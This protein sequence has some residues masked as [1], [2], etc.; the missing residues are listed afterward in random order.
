MKVVVTSGKGGTGKTILAA[1]LAY[2]AEKEKFD[3]QYLD[4]D[5]DE[6]NGHIF[7]KPI[8]Q[9]KE[10]VDLLIPEVDANKCTLCG[11]CS[12]IC[13]FKA[14]IKIADKII[15]FP[16]L[17]HGCGACS[18][19]CEPK[20]IKEI[21]FNVGEI[22]TAQINNLEFVQGKMGIGKSSTSTIIKELKRKI[23]LNSLSFLDSPPGTACPVV[24]SLRNMDYVV[25]V[26][27]PTPFG[28]NDMLLSIDLI[29]E[30]KIPFG[31][32]INRS[33]IGDDEVKKYCFKENI[34]I[35]AEIPNS[36]EVAELYSRGEMIA[37][38]MESYYNDIVKILKKITGRK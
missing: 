12:D 28:L 9:K 34:E 26:T 14:I 6:P 33:D 32:I 24:E 36:R 27:E 21:P 15:T 23:N 38:N 10:S 29:N 17:C 5:V 35:L 11:K 3:V 16:E 19:V 37:E 31:V 13:E 20:A 25:L 30:L 22:E 8:F 4:A 7:F 2:V 1:N 18:L